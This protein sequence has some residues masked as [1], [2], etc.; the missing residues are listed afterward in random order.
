MNWSDILKT[1]KWFSFKVPKEKIEDPISTVGVS[2]EEAP[3]EVVKIDRFDIS[4][5]LRSGVVYSYNTEEKENCGKGCI[6]V[7]Y[8]IFNWFYNKTSPAFTFEHRLGADI[9]LRSEITVISMR[10]TKGAIKE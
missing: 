8:P 5:H 1:P 6:E 9:F 3:K 2:T 7:Y 4:I 10:K